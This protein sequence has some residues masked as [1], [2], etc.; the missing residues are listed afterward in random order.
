MTYKTVLVHVDNSP[1]AE[2]RIRL[3]ATIAAQQH[4]HLAGCA[5]TGITR[6]SD[7][8]GAIGYLDATASQ[9]L[10][11]AGVALRARAEQALESF[12][13][14]VRNADVRSHEATLF[15]DD[16]ASAI[17]L[18]ARY[19]DLAVISQFDPENNAG[20]LQPD[21]PEYV[22]LNSG[23][24]T[25]IVPFAGRF[26]TV[27]RRPLIAWDAGTAATRALGDALPLLKSAKVVDVAV[28]NPEKSGSKHGAQAGDDIA[29][30][31]ARHDIQVE[32]RRVSTPVDTGNAL[33][34]L[35]ADLGS[36]MIVMGCYGHSRF[37]EI[38]LGG[39]TRTV[40][41]TMTVPVLM[42]H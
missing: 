33:L 21:F 35:A 14:I 32:V 17:S 15:N 27:G 6:M 1:A 37:R 38:L 40:L 5:A 34:S 28:F 39:V 9:Y 31:L 7:D 8:A 10:S 20:A 3:A 4:A 23:R 26:E 19:S 2:M 12:D 24:P 11:Q 30:Y 42:S 41:E 36:D 13:R 16:A 22:V 25:L 29:L 18:R